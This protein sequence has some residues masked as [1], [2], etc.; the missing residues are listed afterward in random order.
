MVSLR[1]KVLVACIMF[2]LNGI[3]RSQSDNPKMSVLFWTYSDGDKLFL[4]Q[5]FTRW[6]YIKTI[7][8]LSAGA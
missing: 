5:I 6:V 7:I 8:P 1:V 3:F 4:K 2:L